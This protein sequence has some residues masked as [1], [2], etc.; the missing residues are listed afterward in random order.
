MKMYKDEPDEIEEDTFDEYTT[1]DQ[2]VVN[3]FYDRHG[4]DERDGPP[5]REEE[6]GYVDD[7]SDHRRW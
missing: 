4:Y 7:P 3:S 5:E 2:P 1:R 6:R